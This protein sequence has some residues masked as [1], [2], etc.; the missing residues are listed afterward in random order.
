MIRCYRYL[1]SPLMGPCCRFYP[2][3][4]SYAIAAIES[5]GC[6]YGCY[7]IFKRV[8]RCHPFTEGGFDPIPE[9]KHNANSS[10]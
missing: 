10:H 6:F 2:S 8:F 9:K 7:L 4:S 3:C 1:F 5:Y